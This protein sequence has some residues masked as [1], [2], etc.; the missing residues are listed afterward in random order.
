MS[1]TAINGADESANYSLA[2]C[3]VDEPE[4]RNRLPGTVCGQPRQCFFDQS[5]PGRFLFPLHLPCRLTFRANGI[6][7]H[8]P[9]LLDIKSNPLADWSV[10][11]I[12]ISSATMEPNAISFVRTSAFRRLSL[13]AAF[14]V[15]GS[16]FR[17]P[18]SFSDVAFRQAILPVLARL[19][20]WL[21]LHA[22][23][24]RTDSTARSSTCVPRDWGPEDF[25]G[26]E[27]RASSSRQLLRSVLASCCRAFIFLKLNR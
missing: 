16:V 23:V 20:A 1:C 19:L 4:I 22:R 5:G 24:S 26:L 11:M 21:F 10:P 25:C 13:Q 18:F 17:F 12:G 14:Q 3:C 27:K 6:S 8:E 2:T 9:T 15:S 7:Q